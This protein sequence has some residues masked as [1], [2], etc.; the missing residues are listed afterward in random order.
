MHA[1]LLLQLSGRQLLQP[2]RARALASI[3]RSLRL[4][5]SYQFRSL[6]TWVA[7]ACLVRARFG[8]IDVELI[9]YYCR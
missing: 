1:C 5:I 4:R 6:D 9:W 7:S 8:I 3:V 2:A